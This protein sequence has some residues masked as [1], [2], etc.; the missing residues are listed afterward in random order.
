[1]YTVEAHLSEVVLDGEVHDSMRHTF[2]LVD[3][4]TV[5]Q[6]NE[7]CFVKR[8]KNVERIRVVFKEDEQANHNSFHDPPMNG[9]DIG[10]SGS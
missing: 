10:Q 2:N 9:G 4:V 8:H 5:D 6:W 7:G 1:M 3:P